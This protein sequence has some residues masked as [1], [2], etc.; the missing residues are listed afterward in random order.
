MDGTLFEVYLRAHTHKTL[1]V[2]VYRPAAY[3]AAA[4]QRQD[5]S[6]ASRHERTQYQRGRSH[7]ANQISRRIPFEFIRNIY[8]HIASG[9]RYIRAEMPQEIGHCM[10]VLKIRDAFQRK[11]SSAKKKS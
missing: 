7:P 10:Y 1:Q 11:P 8:C 2:K 9:K 3:C 6:P 5:G 4:G